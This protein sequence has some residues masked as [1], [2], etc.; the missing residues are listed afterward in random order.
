MKI[1]HFD[2]GS[3]QWEEI[4]KGKATASRFKEVVTAKKLELSASSQRYAAQLVAERLGIESTD[5]LPTYW[6]QW[7]TEAEPYAIQEFERSQNLEVE[8]VGFIELN[9]DCGCSPDGLIG[10]NELIEVKC[11]KSETLIQWQLN[12]ALP[13]EYRLQVQGSL[14]ITGRSHCHFWGWHPQMA[15][16]HLIVSRDEEVMDALD[17]WIPAFIESVKA[18]EKCIQARPI[19]PDFS[20]VEMSEELA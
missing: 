15:P 11:P 1:H 3:E 5:P 10:D 16:M 18:M 14:W 6:M 8:R 4:R 12:G 13:D 19:P 2:Q 20:M 7:G 9:D 17:K